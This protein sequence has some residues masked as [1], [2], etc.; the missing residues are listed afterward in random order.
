MDIRP[1]CGWRFRAEADGD[2]SALIAPPYD[3]L[4]ADD[5]QQ[6]LARSDRNIVAVDLP[7]VPPKAEGPDQVYRQAAERLEQWKADGVIRQEDQPALYVYEQTFSWAGRTYA[8]RALLGGVCATKLGEDVIPHEHTFDGPKAD[9]LKLTQCT[10]TQLSPIFGFY[11]DPNQAVSALLAE[12]AGGSPDLHGTLGDVGE[13]L[14]AVTNENVIARVAGLLADVPVFIADGH[15]RYTTAIDYRDS[16]PA[17]ADDP[18]HPARFVM[19]ALVAQNDPGL[20]VLPT[21][22]IVYD[23][24][25]SFSLDQL[26][27]SAGA[28]AWQSCALAEADLADAGA[29]LQPY[30][31]HAMGFLGADAAE[32]RIATLQDSQAMADA[33]PDELDVWR[34][35]DVAILHSLIMDRA[36][37]PWWT[38]QTRVEYTPDA[39]AALAAC[40]NGPA[41]LAVCLQS[42][43]LAAVEQIALAGATMPH[44]STYFYP[45]L[46]TGMVL[47]PVERSAVCADVGRA[48]SE[49][50]P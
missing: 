45:K 7:H 48:R 14:W 28:F 39:R 31:A 35:L 6:L 41:Q 22:R 43:P 29:F 2:V 37:K 19:F 26:I 13:K 30:G 42:T 10:G 25:P 24:A 20:L 44:K 23:L 27:D 11:N 40:R 32:I 16:V 5:K 1:F 17:A 46:A 15:H 12:A 33:A 9:R 8:R 21:H 50:A 38:D 3:V 34:N 4:T 18:D 47:K 49:D 36:L